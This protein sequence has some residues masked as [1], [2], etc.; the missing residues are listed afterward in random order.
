M[1]KSRMSGSARGL[2]EQS[3]L[4]TL[5]FAKRKQHCRH[6]YHIKYVVLVREWFAII[7]V[8]K[9]SVALFRFNPTGSN[10]DSG[11]CSARVY[12]N[13]EET[14]GNFMIKQE[15]LEHDVVNLKKR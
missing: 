14:V 9:A 1:R 5:P 10:R 2:G 8:Y 6:I 12:L 3:P 4:S 11:C 7:P 13:I 15:I